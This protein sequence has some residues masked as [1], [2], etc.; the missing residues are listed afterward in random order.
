MR[1]T[2]EMRLRYDPHATFDV[3]ARDVEYRHDGSQ[4]WLA[5]IY[6][7]QGAGP[8]PM[9]IDIHGGGWCKYDRLHDE[10]VDSALARHG[11]FVASLDF[12]RSTEAPYPAPLADINYAI[13]WFKS[14]AADFNASADAVGAIGYSSGGH[15]AMLG[16]MRPR[17]PR[18]AAIPLPSAPAIDAGLAYVI[19]CWPVIDPHARFLYAQS[20][21]NEFLVSATKNYFRGVGETKEGNPSAILD[22]GERVDTPPALYLQGTADTAVPLQL[23]QDFVVAYARAGGHIELYMVPDAPHIFLWGEGEGT[24]RGMRLIKSFIQR[25]LEHLSAIAPPRESSVANAAA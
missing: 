6:E 15:Q 10:P 14:R 22:R 25:Q 11:I 16:A 24:Q 19:V 13:R 17:D 23:S 20:I 18:Y 12:H 8:F 2:Q 5:R 4:S 21:G 7:P 1:E 3:R 9:L